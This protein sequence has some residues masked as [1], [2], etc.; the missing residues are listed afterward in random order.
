M[1][2]VIRISGF[3]LIV[4][5]IIVLL[6]WV[7]EPLRALWPWLLRLPLPVK[8]GMVG[9]VLGLVVLF[10]SLIAERFEDREKDRSLLDE[11]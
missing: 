6:T 4:A 8:V 9:V 3:L 1:I 10:A 7:I 11:F 2:R 5:G